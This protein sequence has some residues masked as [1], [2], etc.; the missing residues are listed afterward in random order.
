VGYQMS[1]EIQKEQLVDQEEQLN[2]PET[3]IPEIDLEQLATDE[4]IS[5]NSFVDEQMQLHLDIFKGAINN[6]SKQRELIKLIN[7]N[8]NGSFFPDHLEVTIA[9][10]IYMLSNEQQ[11]Q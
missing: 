7:D 1:E 10:R 2:T 5:V 3:E 9:K 6:I 11:N 8:S 4:M